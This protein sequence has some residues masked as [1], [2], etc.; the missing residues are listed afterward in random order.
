MTPEELIAAR[1][2]VLDSLQ[3]FRKENN[4]SPVLDPRG[5]T[6]ETRNTHN[7]QNIYQ[8]TRYG[9]EYRHPDNPFFPPANEEDFGHGG[10]APALTPEEEEKININDTSETD[11]PNNNSNFLFPQESVNPEI[12]KKWNEYQNNIK[13]SNIAKIHRLNKKPYEHPDET[14]YLGGENWSHGGIKDFIQPLDEGISSLFDKIT[15]SRDNIERNKAITEKSPRFNSKK[16]MPETANAWSNFIT[17]L[18][19]PHGGDNN[20]N[21]KEL[22]K[23]TGYVHGQLNPETKEI[24]WNA[25]PEKKAWTHSDLTREI[26]GIVLGGIQGIVHPKTKKEHL[27]ISWVGTPE[28]LRNQG[29]ATTLETEA[30]KLAKQSGYGGLYSDEQ[31]HPEFTKPIHQKLGK[32][33]THWGKEEYFG[34]GGMKEDYTHVGNYIGEVFKQHP[35]RNIAITRLKDEGVISG[36]PSSGKDKQVYSLNTFLHPETGD[37]QRFRGGVLKVVHPNQG[38][39]AQDA[40]LEE[41]TSSQLYPNVTVPVH[42]YDNHNYNWAIADKVKPLISGSREY[43][44]GQDPD[45]TS[46]QKYDANRRIEEGQSKLEDYLN[47][48]SPEFLQEISKIGVKPAETEWAANWGITPVRNEQ[49]NVVRDPRTKRTLKKLVLLDSS[50]AGLNKAVP[51]PEEMM[52]TMYGQTF[53]KLQELQLIGK[54]PLGEGMRRVVYPT[55][56]PGIVAKR[57]KISPSGKAHVGMNNNGD[58]RNK[59]LTLKNQGLDKHVAEVYGLVPIKDNNILLQERVRPIDMGIKDDDKIYE[60]YNKLISPDMQDFFT[61]RLGINDIHPGN[62]GIKKD[63]ETGEKYPV[64]IDIPNN[65]GH[66]GEK[67]VGRDYDKVL[68]W[69]ENT[70]RDEVT[71]QL[72]PLGSGR[73]RAVYAFPNKFAKEQFGDIYPEIVY[74][75][76]VAYQGT[77]ANEREM[78][79]WQQLKEQGKAELAAPVVA[80]ARLK[81]GYRVGILQ[82]RINPFHGDKAFGQNTPWERDEEFTNAGLKD[83][84]GFNFGLTRVMPDGSLGQKRTVQHDI[85]GALNKA[86]NDY[87]EVGNLIRNSKLEQ[88]SSMLKFMGREGKDR[89]VGTLDH[90]IAQNLLGKT[91]ADFLKVKPIVFKIPM[92]NSWEPNANNMEYENFMNKYKGQELV[93]PTLASFHTNDNK[94]I[95]IQPKVNPFRSEKQMMRTLTSDRENELYGKTGLHDL[96]YHNL[97][98]T[99]ITDNGVLTDHNS[100]RPF[101][102]VHGGDKKISYDTKGRFINSGVMREVH[103]S[104]LNPNH[105][106][107]IPYGRDGEENNRA[108]RARYLK[109]K[110]LG[111][112]GTG[113]LEKDLTIDIHGFDPESGRSVAEKAY[114]I[115]GYLA[116]SISRDLRTGGKAENFPETLKDRVLQLRE[117]TRN[118]MNR[119]ISDLHGSNAM[120]NSPYKGDFNNEDEFVNFASKHLVTVDFNAGHDGDKNSLSELLKTTKYVYGELN[121][122]TKAI[123]WNSIDPVDA[124]PF[125]QFTKESP[126]ILLTNRYGYIHPETKQEHLTISWV[127]VP[128][129]MRKKGFATALETEAHKLA[130]QSGYGGLYSTH[131]NHPEATNSIHQKLGKVIQDKEGAE[132]FNKSREY[133]WPLDPLDPSLPTKQPITD[134]SALRPEFAQA[135]TELFKQAKQHGYDLYIRETFRTRPRQDELNKEWHA[136]QTGYAPDIY[137]ERGNLNIDDANFAHGQG[138]AADIGIKGYEENE[139]PIHHQ[140]HKLLFNINPQIISDKVIQGDENHYE[141]SD[142]Y[143]QSVEV[144]L[145]K[146]PFYTEYVKRYAN[147]TP[148]EL[149]KPG[150]QLPEQSMLKSIFEAFGVVKAL[151]SG[152]DDSY[153]YREGENPHLDNSRATLEAIKNTKLGK[154]SNFTIKKQSTSPQVSLSQSPVVTQPSPT[155]SQ[156]NFTSPQKIAPQLSPDL[157]KVATG[158][159]DILSKLREQPTR[160]MP[161]Q[162][163]TSGGYESPILPKPSQLGMSVPMSQS[164]LRD[165]G[166]GYTDKPGD[167][168][169][170][171][172]QLGQNLFGETESQPKNLNLFGESF[173][174]IP[175]TQETQPN[176]GSLFDASSPSLFDSNTIQNMRYGE[177]DIQLKREKEQEAI[178]QA[179][180]EEQKQQEL[181]SRQAQIQSIFNKNPRDVGGFAYD[182]LKEENKLGGFGGILAQIADKIIGPATAPLGGFSFE[183]QRAKNM[184]A[185]EKRNL[186]NEIKKRQI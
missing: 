84:V 98:N 173:P 141:A 36:N 168:S 3:T 56:N 164:K 159:S 29:F 147:P 26:P 107:K 170:I 149:D 105:V 131:Q 86:I 132:F 157:A 50:R 83:R 69:L 146:S 28:H 136:G 143:R 72:K 167:R 27:N 25:I 54:K 43:I 44:F 45:M 124:L 140:L 133:H 169:P 101:D 115:P 17:S 11:L 183:E 37:I 66:G 103:Q 126:R 24:S 104:A 59:Y 88:F 74:K 8:Q 135:I 49:G 87:D 48:S 89:R 57:A 108:E 117:I 153:A 118:P 60:K 114:P 90:K 155:L 64:A 40:M 22:L 92:A 102:Y 63:K 12:N 5:E 79:N 165:T 20:I 65:M 171:V 91:Y 151:Y 175:S 32:P 99:K 123:N 179:Q 2:S 82:R 7:I 185:Q 100:V 81:G 33:Y 55:A 139:T 47:R 93:V 19:I 53:E 94:V 58:E 21:L 95:N 111:L 128:E 112:T 61:N 137:D 119:N 144:D 121:P 182:K 181:Q 9:Q 73:H 16:L 42:A 156:V 138:L 35:D 14:M 186:A 162:T 1:Q 176:V 166:Q 4:L 134:I 116:E 127:G 67:Y 150:T 109:L 154:R 75:D 184:L 122:K 71:A 177:A 80:Q 178:R 31:L 158:Y 96:G 30:H 38:R 172:H 85:A 18:K 10:F 76:P 15:F 129:K 70:P 174:E 110:K 161:R 78:R 41:V 130:K 39:Y 97:A 62:M 51:T 13:T 106:V 163:D 160:S 52:N 180:L 113:D 77:P 6:P 142:Q 152:P 145:T 23:E 148:Q 120:F 46:S 125:N 34:H 68:E